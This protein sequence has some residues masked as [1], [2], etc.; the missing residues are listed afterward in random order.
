MAEELDWRLEMAEEPWMY[1][2]KFRWARFHAPSPDW[3]HEHCVLCGQKFADADSDDVLREGYLA[4]PS[5]AGSEVE[6]EE[7]R[8]TYTDDLRIVAAPTDDVWVCPT[9]FRDFQ[10]RFRWSAERDDGASS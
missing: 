10:E 3:D 8:T 1:D 5:G 6:S 9:C 2:A 4:Q 7:A